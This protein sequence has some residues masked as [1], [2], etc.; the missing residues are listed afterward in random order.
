MDTKNVQTVYNFSL[1]LEDT[2]QG[3]KVCGR[4]LAP[5]VQESEPLGLAVIIPGFLGYMDWGFYPYLAKTLAD[6]Q[7]AVILFNHSTGGVGESGKPYSGL[8]KLRFMTVERDLADIRRIFAAIKSGEISG[9][10]GLANLPVFLI[11][12]SKGGAVAVLSSS[13]QPSAA[14]VV[15]INSVADMLRIPKEKA[16]EI[17]ERGYQEKQLPGTKITMKVDKEYWQQLLDNPDRYDVLR[18][19]KSSSAKVFIVRGNEDE[20]ITLDETRQII[21]AA[22]K[23][24]QII[25]RDGADHNLGSNGVSDKIEQ[26]AHVLIIYIAQ[27][28]GRT[29]DAFIASRKKSE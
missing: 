18:A 7:Y 25:L 27:W 6:R 23:G 8:D 19:L 20:I 28:I 11:G 10:P 15:L 24:T 21:K 29:R 9:I 26:N 13:V 16:L 1:P 2:I 12:H 17:I 4:L 3:L 14:G 5:A 22:P